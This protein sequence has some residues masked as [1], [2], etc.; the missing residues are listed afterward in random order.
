MRETSNWHKKLTRRLRDQW[1]SDTRITPT[2]LCEIELALTLHH[3]LIP[4]APVESLWVLLTGYP[5]P[6]LHE[7]NWTKEQWLMLGT[8]RHLLPYYRSPFPWNR[9]LTLYFSL[10]DFERIQLR[11]DGSCSRRH[12]M[13]D[14]FD[15]IGCLKPTAKYRKQRIQW[16]SPGSYEFC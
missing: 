15:F 11:P 7:L 14:R 1:P 12:S 6:A 16:A 5:F 10:D 2:M 4:D 13:A 9:A 3:Q 8:A